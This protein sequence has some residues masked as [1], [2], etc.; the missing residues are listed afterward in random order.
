MGYFARLDAHAI[1]LIREKLPIGDRINLDDILAHKRRRNPARIDR[2]ELRILDE[3]IFSRN[4][5]NISRNV[6]NMLLICNR[7][8]FNRDQIFACLH[9]LAY[10]CRPNVC[11]NFANN[12]PFARVTV[13]KMEEFAQ[14]RFARASNTECEFEFR[15]LC[16]ECARRYSAIIA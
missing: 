5:A 10:L 15:M 4:A 1:G 14:H 8:M 13:A 12:Q 7:K 11:E 9:L 16:A 3:I 2:H 6:G